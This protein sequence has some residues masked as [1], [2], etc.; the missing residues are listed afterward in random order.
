MVIR[1]KSAKASPAAKKAR[2]KPAT[3]GRLYDSLYHFKRD[4]IL[5]VAARQFYEKG[6]RATTINDIAAE[7]SVTKPFIYSYFDNKEDLLR[8]LFDR[9]VQT[10]LA[11]FADF[12][13]SA[14][15]PE[16]ALGELVRRFVK[17][18]IET[19]NSTGVFW[20]GDRDLPLVDRKQA[21]QFRRKF[22]V[23]FVAVLDRGVEAGAFQVGDR[24]LTIICIE[25]MIN[26][27]YTWYRPE[28]RLS[29]AQLADY[30]AV[31][32]VNMVTGRPSATNSAV[33]GVRTA[34]GARR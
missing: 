2:A 6:Y 33:A 13:A 17:V 32:C 22:E 31:L 10:A 20:R 11:A 19:R 3:K 15:S 26:W 9:T 30:I 14:G 21:V 28:G 4:Q 34:V 8:E 5:E 27:I 1:K 16:Q 24:Q 12:D 29:A 23:P 25:G 7:L 18:V